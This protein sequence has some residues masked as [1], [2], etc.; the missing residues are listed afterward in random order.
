MY[1]LDEHGK[2]DADWPTSAQ[3]DRAEWLSA[4]AELVEMIERLNQWPR[5]GSSIEEE[6]EYD[7]WHA[8]QELLRRYKPAVLETSSHASQQRR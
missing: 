5:V 3:I 4:V 2:Y 7:D 8:A 6:G 1:H